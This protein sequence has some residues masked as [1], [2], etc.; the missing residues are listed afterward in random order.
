MIFLS[1][2]DMASMA[3]RRA[4][5]L[6]MASASSLSSFDMLSRAPAL[7]SGLIDSSASR[8]SAGGSE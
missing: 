5:G 8:L 3:E 6:I 7:S 1:E 2:G 4:S